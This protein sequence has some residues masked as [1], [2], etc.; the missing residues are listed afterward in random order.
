MGQCNS[1]L[2]N[3]TASQTDIESRAHVF[4]GYEGFLEMFHSW[5][6]SIATYCFQM[7]VVQVAK[8]IPGVSATEL[9]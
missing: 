3:G 4:G 8:Q 7:T 1:K 2:F 9:S 6:R 5:N